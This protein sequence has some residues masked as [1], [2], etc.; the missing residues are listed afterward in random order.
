MLERSKL[1]AVVQSYRAAARTGEGALVVGFAVAETA[2][3]PLVSCALLVAVLIVA[4]IAILAEPSLAKRLPLSLSVAVLCFLVGLAVGLVFDGRAM[5][6]QL[7]LTEV[8]TEAAVARAL[9]E[10]KTPPREAALPTTGTSVSHSLS[11][12]PPPNLLH[13][14]FMGDYNDLT[15]STATVFDGAGW[16]CGHV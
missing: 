4:T 6:A 5:R 11:M 13:S 7:P 9:R 1:Q 2:G 14:L 15:V 12:Q 3:A 16:S 10:A 8:Q